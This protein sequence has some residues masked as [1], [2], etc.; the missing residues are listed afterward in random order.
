[1]SSP[2]HLGLKTDFGKVRG[3]IKEGAITGASRDQ[4]SIMTVL[5][6]GRPCAG[7]NALYSNGERTH[8]KQGTNDLYTVRDIDVTGA[9]SLCGCMCWEGFLLP[10][11]GE[12]RWLCG[13]RR[14][15][16]VN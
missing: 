9:A 7:Q 15:E 10:E 2:V 16:P 3:Q 14:V 5:S 11:A 8:P 4:L 12:S 1:M 13:E 6:A